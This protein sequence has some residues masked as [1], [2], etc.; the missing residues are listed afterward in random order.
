[1]HRGFN[2]QHHFSGRALPGDATKHLYGKE[3]HTT[4]GDHHFCE[5]LFFGFTQGLQFNVKCFPGTYI[6]FSQ[7]LIFLKTKRVE[8]VQKEFLNL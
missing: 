5:N 3:I 6:F 8:K 7:S 4:G 2:G 1:M